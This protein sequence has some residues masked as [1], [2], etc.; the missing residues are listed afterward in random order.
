ML[1]CSYWYAHQPYS[2]PEKLVKARLQRWMIRKAFEQYRDVF[3]TLCLLCLP[4][5]AAYLTATR[6]ASKKVLVPCLAVAALVIAGTAIHGG[7]GLAPFMIDLVTPW[8]VQGDGP[9]HTLGDKPV[10]LAPL[11]RLSLTSFLAFCLCVLVAAIFSRRHR[12]FEGPV[13][14]NTRLPLSWQTTFYLFVPFIAAYLLLLAPRAVFAIVYDRY[15]IPIFALFLIVLLRFYQER[16]REKAP[17]VCFVTLALFSGYAIASTHDFFAMERAEVAAVQ[18]VL[19][20]GV[21]RTELQAGFE[22]DAPV[23]LNTTGY[24]NDPRIEVPAG[25]YKPVQASSLVPE[26]CR[27]VW[28]FMMPAIHPRYFVAFSPRSCLAPSGLPPVTYSAWWPPFRREIYIQRLPDPH[29]APLAQEHAAFP[30]ERISN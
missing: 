26:Q 4:V 23:Q 14:E 17:A 6:K 29:S 22:L 15:T 27:M 10:V 5:L 11:L 1:A 9:G 3:L 7:N 28:S 21:P 19:K 13:S 2:L 20:A 16:I 30:S 24:I 8:G 25:A 18:Q 12:R